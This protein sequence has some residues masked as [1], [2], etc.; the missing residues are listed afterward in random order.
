MMNN[1]FL[2]ISIITSFF[3][4]TINAYSQ[5]LKKIV[6]ST[7]YDGEVYFV[8]ANNKEIKQGQYLK[9]FESVSLNDKAIGSFGEFDNNKKTGVWIFCDGR[10]PSNPLIAMGEYSDDKKNGKW[11]FFY[12]P[13]L[14]SN[15]SDK[16]QILDYGKLTKVHL[17]DKNEQKFQISLDTTGSKVASTGNYL[18][19]KKVGIWNY[20]KPDGSLVIKYDYSSNRLIYVKE[21]FGVEE[22]KG[23]ERF[24]WLFLPLAVDKLERQPINRNSTVTLEVSTFQDSLS[25]RRLSNSGAA[26]YAKIIENVI[27][28]MPTDWMNY[29]PRLEQNKIRIY[30]ND[31]VEGDHRKITIDTIRLQKYSYKN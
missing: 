18:E 10:H 6:K 23:I 2:K 13:L 3:M 28:N 24:K 7:L 25:T 12:T 27:S 1:R 17:P 26:A 8:R 20:Y 31:I 9:Y 11:I 19:N 22:L 29:D 15:D 21:P 16:F 5:E 14:K 4:L 30:V